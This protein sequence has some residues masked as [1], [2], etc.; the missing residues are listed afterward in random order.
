MEYQIA[1]DV[2]E[3]EVSM[4]KSRYLMIIFQYAR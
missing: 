4:W 2:A 1:R 3:G